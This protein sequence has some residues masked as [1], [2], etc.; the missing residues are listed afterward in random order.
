MRT[1][2]A[3]SVLVVALAPASAAAQRPIGSGQVFGDERAPRQLCFGRPCAPG[4]VSRRRGLIGWSEIAGRGGP[5]ARLATPARARSGATP[6]APARTSSVAR[7]A[8][9]G[10][11]SPGA[12]QLVYAGTLDGDG[13]LNGVLLRGAIHLLDVLALELAGGSLAGRTG[14][15]DTR[16]DVPM[17]AGLRVQAPLRHRV[18]RLYGAIATGLVLRTTPGRDDVDPMAVWPFA[19]GAGLEL[20]FPVRGRVALGVVFDVR[21]NIRVPVGGDASVGPAWSAGLSAS[22]Y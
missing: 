19:V 7:E 12:L 3:L 5:R 17:M 11:A 18:A 14:V 9:S 22:W 21:L 16:V 2:L 8:P 6:T 20:G 4:G 10:G 1:R 15:D 13:A